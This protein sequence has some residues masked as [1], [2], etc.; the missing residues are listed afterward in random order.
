MP[1]P[2]CFEPILSFKT[3]NIKLHRSKMASTVDPHL[4]SLEDRWRL[5]KAQDDQKASLI[6]DLFSHISGLAHKLSEVELE[7]K[8]RNLVVKSMCDTVDGQEQQV[9][10]LQTE[11][12]KHCFA[13]VLI[14]GDC[15]P[16]MDDL[17]EQGLEGG[18]KASS[19]VRQ[20]ML[21]ELKSVDPSLP[22]HL[23]FVVRVFANLKGLA[24]TYTELGTILDPSVLYEFVRGFNMTNPMCEFVDAGNGKECAD[25]KMKGNFEFAVADVHCRY[26]LFGASADS[27]Y[28]RLLGSHLE[29]EEIR[30]KVIL[31][32]GPPFAKEL[33]EIRDRFRVAT[34]ER[35]FRRKKLINFKRKVSDYITPPPTPSPDYAS[36]AAKPVLSSWGQSSS[37]PQRSTTVLTLPIREVYRNRAGQR[38]DPPIS[39]S[40]QDF[41]IMKNKK[42]CNNFHLTGRCY[43]KEMSGRCSHEHG[44]SPSPRELQALR[45]VA[46]QSYCHSG[47]DCSDPNC[48]FGHSALGK[49]ATERV[50]G[51]SFHWSYTTLI[52]RL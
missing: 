24:K 36:A 42:M 3:Q 32:E 29:T 25:E 52:R 2:D 33:A 7:L 35:V 9:K 10:Q 39:C 34:F 21:S 26:V 46:R 27:G 11:K 22:H 44:P 19:F 51:T 47:L 48:L 5:C 41:I 30:K 40:Q 13:L 12:D 16:F 28:A 15:M 8:E 50:V 23:Q 14:D 37:Q 31:L 43:H 17:I 4:P 20:A 1:I 6:S 49:T 18:K 38:V 45:A